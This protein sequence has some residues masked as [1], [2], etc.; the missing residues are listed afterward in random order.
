M[1]ASP[2]TRGPF[3][4]RNVF[5]R[6]L[7]ND[8]PTQS[9]RCLA[10]FRAIENGELSAWTT[11]VVIA[12]IVWV[13]QGRRYRLSP[14]EIRERLLPLINLPNI[15]LPRKRLYDRAFQLFAELGIDYVDCYHAAVLELQGETE[16]YSYD[17]HFDRIP[18][19]RRLEP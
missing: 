14:Q 3:L 11:D 6:H 17:R 1:T 19:V 8:D 16:I 13:L 2:S 18:S 15:R 10:L 9:P 7:L 12:E 5:I 4:D